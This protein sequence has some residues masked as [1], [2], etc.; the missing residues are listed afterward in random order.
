MDDFA[1]RIDQ[2]RVIIDRLQDP[3]LWFWT[4]A[5]NDVLRWLH[6]RVR[7][8]ATI[9]ELGCGL[10]FFLHAL[11]REG[12]TAVGLDVAEVACELNR[13]DGFKVWHG[14]LDTMPPGWI[15]PDA[16]VA[17]FM[18]HHLEDPLGFLRTIRQRF[19]STPLAIAQYGPSN[20]SSPE[21]ASPP[22]TLIRWN[23]PALAT[24]LQ[25][26]GYEPDVVNVASTGAESTL[27]LPARALQRL[28]MLPAAYRLRAQIHSLVL[29]LFRRWLA[30]D[31]FVILAYAEP[32][33]Q[34]DPS[35]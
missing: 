19:P 25:L 18:L 22:R 12:F 2:R 31:A 27:M 3:R 7:P 14:V 8:G 17:F 26:A 33:Q 11:R 29:P 32:T 28:T 10:G 23:A 21:R 4:P 13:R 20:M 30:R 9:L 15:A 1:R 5:F 34:T 35:D 6:R 24:A 16:V